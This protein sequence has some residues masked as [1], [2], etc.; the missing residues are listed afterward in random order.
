MKPADLLKEAPFPECYDECKAAE[1]LG[2]GECEAVCPQKF[3]ERGKPIRE[4][5]R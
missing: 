5:S 4:V 3:D 1:Y 2:V